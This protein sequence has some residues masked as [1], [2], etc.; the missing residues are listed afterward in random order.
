MDTGVDITVIFLSAWP[1]TWPM[2]SLGQAIEGLEG[3]AQTF[4]SQWP[5]LFKDLEGQ[6]AT[7]RPCITTA[8]I[9]LWGQDVLAAWGVGLEAHF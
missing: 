6:T 5:V 1:P 3:T 9:N 2:A 7:V 4:V 8:L